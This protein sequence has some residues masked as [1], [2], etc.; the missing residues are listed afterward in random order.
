MGLLVANR[1]F[2]LY[3][4][5]EAGGRMFKN[6]EFKD[7]ES[8]DVWWDINGL[9]NDEYYSYYPVVNKKDSYNLDDL[10]RLSKGGKFAL[11]PGYFDFDLLLGT[12]D[13]YNI[14]YK[15]KKRAGKDYKLYSK[16]PYYFYQFAE[17]M[18]LWEILTN[19]IPGSQINFI[20]EMFTNKLREWRNVSDA[21]QEEVF[22]KFAEATI[23]D[24]FSENW[25]NLRIEMQDLILNS[26]YNGLLLDTIIL[27]NHT[28]KGGQTK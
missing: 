21:N 8:M 14:F 12:D 10:A 3:M 23:K 15:N 6:K 19:N 28:I 4:L 16:R 1:K 11:Y 2:P 20:E 22:T 24:A 26:A 27:F 7:P 9:R 25:N 17:M 13:R 18:D 5:L